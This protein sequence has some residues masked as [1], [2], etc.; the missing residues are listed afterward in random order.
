MLNCRF[1]SWFIC[2]GPLNYIPF[3][4][5][6][7]TVTAY[8]TLCVTIYLFLDSIS[9]FRCI[10]CIY[11]IVLKGHSLQEKKKRDLLSVRAKPLTMAILILYCCYRVRM[12]YTLHIRI[13]QD[14]HQFV[15]ILLFSYKIITIC[16]GKFFTSTVSLTVAKRNTDNLFSLTP[17]INDDD[18]NNNNSNDVSI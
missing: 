1:Y 6:F 9:L 11:L 4:S 2:F 5:S 18:D 13:I 16:S 17:V 14:S 15:L 7:N 12:L 3:S 10:N 8:C